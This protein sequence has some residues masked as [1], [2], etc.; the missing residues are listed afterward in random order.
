MVFDGSSTT[1]LPTSDFKELISD[2]LLLEELGC[3]AVV[4]E[5]VPAKLAKIISEKLSIP[6]IGIGAGNSCDGQ[7]LVIQDML[8]MYSDF[9]PKFVKKYANLSEHIKNAVSN[10]CDEVRSGE[11]VGQLIDR[12]WRNRR[13]TVYLFD[14]V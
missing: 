1:I 7:V 2:A 13:I 10:Y 8:G 3:V 5:C 11:K 6:T 4:L 14:G 12:Q 9:T